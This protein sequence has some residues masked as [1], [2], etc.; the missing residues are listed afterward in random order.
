MKIVRG[1]DGCDVDADLVKFW[2]D[3]P[4]CEDGT[5]VS[6]GTTVAPLNPEIDPFIC[7]SINAQ[8]CP[9]CLTG[10]GGTSPT[11]YTYT[12]AGGYKVTICY[13]L[14]NPPYYGCD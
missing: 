5:G 6:L 8:G 11:Y 2:I 3:N 14:A 9:E 12:T 10:D 1:P 7:T 4:T 13:D